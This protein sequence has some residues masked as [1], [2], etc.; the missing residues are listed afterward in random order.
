[1]AKQGKSGISWTDETWNPVR[2]CSRVSAGCRNCYAETVAARFSGPG[3]PY[4][5]LIARGGQWNGQVRLVPEKLEEPLRWRRSR[6]VFVNSMSDL[7]HESVPDEYIERVWGVMAEARQHVFQVL[8]K[9]PERMTHHLTQ[10]Q[11]R[12]WKRDW[13]NIWLGVSVENQASANERIP[14]LLQAP[15][16]VR[17]ISAEPLLGPVDLCLPRRT[18]QGWSG[19]SGVGCGECCNGDRCDD[20][21]HLDRRHCPYC[22]GTGN[23]RPIDW[24]VAGG[25]SGLDARPMHPDWV[26]SLRDQCQDAGVPFHFKQ[27]GEWAP[28]R[29]GEEH[30][31]AVWIT[32]DGRTQ[33]ID[34]DGDLWDESGSTLVHRHG[35][36]RAG[37]ELDGQV[38]NEYPNH[39]E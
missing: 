6:M 13:P 1:M 2:G 21:T 31:T 35:K 10:R 9:R 37:R 30:Y 25:E 23:G 22:R 38:W 18:W 39:Q 4:E 27:W 8:T 32:R 7:F 15:A 12:G 26:R 19:E 16:A 33:E 28:S 14:P 29:V 34:A 20:P 11:R 36:R 17:W 5:G 24:V 3:Q